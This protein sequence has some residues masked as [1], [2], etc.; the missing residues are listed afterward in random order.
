[1]KM[2]PILK[3]ELQIGSRSIKMS[4]AIMGYNALLAFIAVIV[5]LIS[6]MDTVT[7]VYDYK[8][9]IWVFP[10]A[11]CTEFGLISLLIPIITA[12]S[13]SGEREKQTLDVMLTTPINPF[14]I[15]LGKLGSAMAMILMFVISSVPILSVSFILGGLNWF[16]LLGFIVMM[17]YLGVYVG[18]V[19]VFCSSVVKK[20]V[21]ATILTIVIGLGIMI[22]TSIIFSIAASICSAIASY[23]ATSVNVWAWPFILLLNPYSVIFDFIMRSM[24][25]YSVY[26]IMKDSNTMPAIFVEIGR[27]WILI[28]M[29]V[30]LFISFL[31]LKL[32]ASVISPVKPRK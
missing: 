25:S 12:S 1:M 32:A 30:N 20:S 14:S 24:G 11:A 16:S 13:V 9:L 4:I 2:N 31:F 26:Q 18:S 17:V 22:G 10:V 6:N 8:S 15:A 19:G 28:G 23:N 5:L 7:S 27:F 3:K 29:I 21:V